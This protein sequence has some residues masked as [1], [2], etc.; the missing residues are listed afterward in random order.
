MSP[1]TS[2][3]QSVCQMPMIGTG[4]TECEVITLVRCPRCRKMLAKCSVLG[5]IEIACPRCKTLVRNTFA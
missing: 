3:E 4:H 2:E 5:T 1:T